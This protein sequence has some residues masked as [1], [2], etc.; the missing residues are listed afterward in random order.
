MMT[1]MKEKLIQSLL[2]W[3]G[4]LFAALVS[5]CGSDE[6]T[7]SADE[8]DEGDLVFFGA[9]TDGSA[10][11]RASSTPMPEGGR[12]AC[13]MY[14]QAG[15]DANSYD[16]HSLAWLQVEGSAG[17]ALY[18]QASF[19]EPT[20]KDGYGFD[21]LSSIF[22]W[23]NRKEHTYVALADF[24]KLTTD[25]GTNEGSLLH[26]SILEK[27]YRAATESSPEEKLYITFNLSTAGKSSCAEQPDPIRA[28]TTKQPKSYTPEANRVSLYFKHCFSQVQ[29]NLARSQ[30]SSVE[31]LQPE[32]IVSVELMGVTAEGRVTPWI[33]A[34]GTYEK[35][36]YKPVVA[37][38]FTTAEWSA[39]EGYGTHFEMFPAST[40]TT[41]YIKSYN[42]IAFG[43]L[44]AIRIVWKEPVNNGNGG[45]T[46]IEHKVTRAIETDYQNLRSG[47]R[48]IFNIQIRRGVLAVITASIL[49]WE[50]DPTEYHTD[51]SVTTKNS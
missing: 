21:R 44:R 2:P 27:E 25:D 31:D 15:V 41:G 3:M 22:Y 29:V 49:P 43:M 5:A 11:T 4:V 42:A 50:V 14:Y 26:P 46:Y 47:T 34:D 28:I 39:S 20:D 24:N 45:T 51:G 9:G 19:V 16:A 13:K 18:R 23:Q 48:H 38:D 1:K 36:S 12:F 37:K 7:L 10:S 32:N 8:R 35:P 33:Y 30:D 40:T 6:P 17:N